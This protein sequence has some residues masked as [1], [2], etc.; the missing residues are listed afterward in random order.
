[1]SLGVPEARQLELGPD[2]SGAL[3]SLEEFDA[4]VFEEGWRYQLIHGVLVV[5][6]APLR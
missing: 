5:S 3:L 4:A 6:P 2:S 1:M